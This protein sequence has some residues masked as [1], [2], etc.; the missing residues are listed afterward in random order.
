M[1]VRQNHYRIYK[2]VPNFLIKVYT[3]TLKNVNNVQFQDITHAVMKKSVFEK[4]HS[5]LFYHL[6]KL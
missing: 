3:M 1:T 4:I 6:S 2:K 5:F